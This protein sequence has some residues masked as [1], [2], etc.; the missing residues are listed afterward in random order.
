MRIAI[1]GS[2]AM[3]SLFAAR[4]APLVDVTMIAHWPPQ[5]AALQSRGLALEEP[6]GRHVHL[7]PGALHVTSEP[8]TV[9]PADVALVLVK[10]YQ[11]VRATGEAAAVLAPHGLAL[12]LQNGLGNLETLAAAVGHERAL[13]G[14]TSEGATLL[15]PGL[16]RHAGRG[17]TYVGV[18][19]AQR[20]RTAALA[21]LLEEAGFATRLDSD[22][23]ALLWAK[24]AV[25]AGINPLT[26]LLGTPNGF[27]AAHQ[28]ARALMIAAAEEAADVARALGCHLPLPPAGE[29]VLQVALATAANTSSMLQDRR[30]GRPTE[31]EAIT[32]AVVAHG[33]AQSVSTPVNSAL[34][35]L[36]RAA[37]R[38][39][40]WQP[41]VTSLQPAPLRRLFVDL[42]ALP[43]TE[44]ERTRE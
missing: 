19:A 5:L 3:G 38:G 43:T 21:T 24:V 37:E 18:G 36:V 39:E 31:I 41:L 2:G 42:A 26:A 25:N 34:L 28:P 22:V 15:A 14:T 16:V 6:D 33:A 7:P 27:L 9:A 12:T 1:V 23:A 10:A 11:S 29:R 4:L 13:A 20:A 44:T 8:A 17:L 32:G 30:N 35:T 40:P